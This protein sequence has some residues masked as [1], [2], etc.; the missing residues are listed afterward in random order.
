V[1]LVI[2]DSVTL[3][4]AEHRGAITVVGSHGGASAAQYAL[5]HRPHAIISNDAGGGLD[6]AG[7]SGLAMY[8]A[9]GIAAATVS[10]ASARIG[11]GHST[12][13][14]GILSHVNAC[15]RALGAREGLSCRQW[16]ADLGGVPT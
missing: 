13:E 6:D 5:S 9:A 1:K 14:T 2:L 15:A 3:V 8:E 7:F 16:C 4:R 11:E 10:S 12:Y